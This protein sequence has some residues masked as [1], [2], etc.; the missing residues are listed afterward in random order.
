LSPWSPFVGAVP[1]GPKLTLGNKAY[2]YPCSVI[3]KALVAKQLDIKL[4]TNKENVEQ[5]YAID[6]SNTTD[7]EVNLTKKAGTL[8]VNSIC[9]L[10]LDRVQEGEGKEQTTSFIN[11]SVSLEQFEDDGKAK[12]AFDGDKKAIKD[13][14]LMPAYRDTSFFAPAQATQDGGP[15]LVRPKV[16]HKNLLISFS[17][18]VEDDDTDGTKTVVQLE[19]IVKDI[20]SRVDKGEGLEPK[21][22]NGV[23][24]L[25]DQT[26]V[27]SCMSVNYA[28]IVAA[29]GNGTELYAPAVASTQAY[30]P[31]DN[32]GQTPEQL[33]STC[34]FT[35][36]TQTEA[37]SMKDLQTAYGQ[38][39]TYAQKF[40]HHMA[41][42]IV[43][44]ESKEKAQEYLKKIKEEAEKSA[45]EGGEQQTTTTVKD[46]DL[47]EGGILMD[48]KQEYS[49]TE[50][51]EAAS[52]TISQF[53][54][55]TKGANIL[56]FSTSYVD[57]EKPYR[58]KSQ[59][60]N[61]D[62][63]KKIYKELMLAPKRAK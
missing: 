22:F 37:Q 32:K 48:M 14:K 10:K 16:L 40:P 46:L 57:Q 2:I 51:G 43:V 7:K 20:T 9:N 6:P 35:F 45:G 47:G 28:K 42:Q 49:G 52:T 50:A 53:A 5:R 15:V 8:A 26:F 1:K 34:S 23:N 24:K 17:V 11:V 13:A 25:K 19:P 21:N 54:Y 18:P 12:E 62:Q 41:T 33:A 58:A 29:M 39:V 36:R 56:V 61:Q 44:T 38:E 4:D 30:A 63:L 59:K 55:V 27:D 31:T 60:L 3:D